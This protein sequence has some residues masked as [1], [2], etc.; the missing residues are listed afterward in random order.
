MQ[1]GEQHSEDARDKELMLLLCHEKDEKAMRELIERHQKAVYA[2]AYRMM[3][4]TDDAE[5]ITQRTFIRVWKAAHSYEPDAQF[6]TWLFTITKNLVFNESRRRKRKPTFSLDEHE[7]SSP[8]LAQAAST[9]TSPQDALLHQELS[10]QVDKALEALPEK[11]RM[12]LQLRRFQNMSYEEIAHIL[13]TSIS[14]TKSLLFRA[15]QQLKQT[16][17]RYL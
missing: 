12:A 5:D 17:S 4:N 2:F 11:A 10:A 7:E 1:Q 14:A 16:L 13:D 6:T 9:T 15:R 8:A 3:G